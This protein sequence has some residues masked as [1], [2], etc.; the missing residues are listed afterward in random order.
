MV[1]MLDKGV[2]LTTNNVCIEFIG[3]KITS[4]ILGS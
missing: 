2:K 3:T 4:K 1:Y